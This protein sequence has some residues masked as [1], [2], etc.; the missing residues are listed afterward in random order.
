MAAAAA[1]VVQMKNEE[2]GLA[3]G[4]PAEPGRLGVDDLGDV[5]DDLL[6]VEIAAAPDDELMHDAG[7]DE[8]ELLV[9]LERAELQRAVGQLVEVAREEMRSSRS[10][11]AAPQ[12]LHQPRRQVEA[13]PRT[14]RLSR[15]TTNAQAAGRD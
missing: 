14:A 5:V 2:I 11:S 13:T 9:G 1:I 7:G 15:P 12:L 6:A 10:G 8:V 3:I 4:Q